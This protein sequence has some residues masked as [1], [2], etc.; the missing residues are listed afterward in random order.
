MSFSHFGGQWSNHFGGQWSK[1]KSP[2][3]KNALSA[4][5]THPGAYKWYVLTA[6]S[7]QQQPTI[8]FPGGQEVTS[9][10]TCIEARWGFGIGHEARWAVRI[11]GGSVD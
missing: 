6:T 5:N 10:A 9:A 2:G 7:V 3:T 1:V 8:T 4:A 11:E